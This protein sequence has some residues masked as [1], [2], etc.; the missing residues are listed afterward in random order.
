MPG[1]NRERL[2]EIRAVRGMTMEQLANKLGITK[3]MVSKYEDGKSI[4]QIEA[5]RKMATVLS[6][7]K[8]F[9][10][11]ESVALNTHS[12]TLFL[13]A[14]L[15][16]PKKT[17]AYARVISRWGY[18]L[19]QSIENTSQPFIN[20]SIDEQLTIPEKAMELR[21]QWGLGTQPI[22]DMVALLESRGF[23]IFTIDSPELKTEAYSQIINGIP[24]IVINQ[25]MGTA[26]RRRF[27]LAH[28][29]GHMVLHGHLVDWDFDLRDR[30]IEHEAQQ[31]AEYFLL[32]AGGFDYSFVSPKMEHLISLKKEWLVSL[33]AI[34]IHCENIGLIDA[35]KREFLQRQ[36]NGR[37]WQKSEPLDNEIEYEKPHAIGNYILSKVIDSDTFVDFFDKVQLPID[38]VE[39]L[40][41]L[42]NGSLMKFFDDSLK[43]YD[44]VGFNQMEFKQLT[45]FDAGG[46][47]YA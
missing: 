33:S 31:F 12:S 16:T 38:H 36:I 17:R 4:P 18:E 44:V 3:Q 19:A 2:T 23:N 22:K 24:I 37:G 20:I 6:V 39:N 34:V 46:D 41:S 5:I 45:L 15:V 1:F 7:P 21:R 40:C 14:P 42:P 29:L 47:Y 11:K 8:K 26:V 10:F 28:E 9:L 35:S 30:E 13:R 32:P 25:Q 43:N 27:S